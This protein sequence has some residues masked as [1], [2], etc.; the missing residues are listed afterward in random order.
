MMQGTS[1]AMFVGIP[2][3]GE[4]ADEKQVSS[5]RQTRSKV[6]AW[7]TTHSPSAWRA[8]A[9]WIEHT[10]RRRAVGRSRDTFPDRLSPR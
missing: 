9:R 3:R 4:G 5:I 2:Q 1:P 8:D 10:L 7:Q 6:R